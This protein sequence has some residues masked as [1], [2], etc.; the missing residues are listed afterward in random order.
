MV[1]TR[2]SISGEAIWVIYDVVRMN[3]LSTEPCGQLIG[4]LQSSWTKLLVESSWWAHS[5]GNIPLLH[6]LRQC[7]C[8]M[9]FSPVDLCGIGRIWSNTPPAVIVSLDNYAFVSS[10][11]DSCNSL[12][13]GIIK[14]DLQFCINPKWPKTVIL[15]P[16]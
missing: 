11:L 15:K 1:K 10:W 4:S 7:S 3:G 16:K 5:L 8:K 13:I 9:Q 6:L 14:S 12:L 2:Q